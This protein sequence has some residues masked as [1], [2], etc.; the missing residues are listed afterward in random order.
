MSLGR[1]VRGDRLRVLLG[2]G[3]SV[4]RG[5]TVLELLAVL[6]VMAL[7]ASLIAVSLGVGA[8]TERRARDMDSIH[9][10]LL[11]A[12]AQA[13]RSQSPCLVLLESKQ[14]MSGLGG[15]EAVGAARIRST[16]RSR[17]LQSDVVVLDSDGVAVPAGW[18][19]FSPLGEAFAGVLR[20]R[21]SRRVT[22]SLPLYEA[23]GSQGDE[24]AR[25]SASALELHGLLMRVEGASGT[26]RWRVADASL[27]LELGGAGVPEELLSEPFSDVLQPVGVFEALVLG[28]IEREERYELARD[29]LGPTDDPRELSNRGVTQRFASRADE[30]ARLAAQAVERGQ[31]SEQGDGDEGSAAAEEFRIDE[32]PS[33]L[34]AGLVMEW[35]Y[36]LGVAYGEELFG[37]GGR[38]VFVGAVDVESV[39]RVRGLYTVFSF[40]PLSGRPVREDDFERRLGR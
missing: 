9:T 8:D 5:F 36:L 11:E 3:R 22:E 17:D 31:G 27:L 14:I 38:Q 37:V 15:I 33:G 35:S 26:M 25:S 30:R 16:L 24:V 12:R 6:V 40:D 28:D 2:C 34:E 1:C 32:P 10:T 18:V 23:L 13:M 7:I 21:L 20:E 4:R 29:R 19:V 39:S